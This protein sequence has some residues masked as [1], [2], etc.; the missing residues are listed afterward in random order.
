MYME[1]I[2]ANKRRGFHSR[3]FWFKQHRE[4]GGKYP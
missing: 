1:C 4:Q 2:Q 3:I